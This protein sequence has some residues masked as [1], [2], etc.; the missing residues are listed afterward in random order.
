MKIYGEFIVRHIGQSVTSHHWAEKL[1]SAALYAGI[2]AAGK[3]V[4]L[5]EAASQYASNAEQRLKSVAFP[6]ATM[7]RNFAATASCAMQPPKADS[8]A[9]ATFGWKFR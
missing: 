3:N 4:R 8:T 5:G 2:K 7:V 9:Y 1:A 6:R